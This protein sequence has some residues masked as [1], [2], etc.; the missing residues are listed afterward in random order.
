MSKKFWIAVNGLL[1]AVFI[2]AVV[3][4][5]MTIHQFVSWWGLI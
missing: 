1:V 3:L 5:G 4:L 2:I